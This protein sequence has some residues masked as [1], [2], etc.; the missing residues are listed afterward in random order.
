MDKRTGADLL[1]ECMEQI[2]K[3]LKKAE[4]NLD[5]GRKEATKT[6]LAKARGRIA[7]FLTIM[8]FM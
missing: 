2:D 4:D 1:R 7:N 5:F 8:G 6:E 3:D